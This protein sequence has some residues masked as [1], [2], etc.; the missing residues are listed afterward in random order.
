LR[1]FDQKIARKFSAQGS[2][3]DQHDLEASKTLILS[4]KERIQE[5][6]SDHA[7]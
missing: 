7:A 2:L 1:I 6:T 4:L 3:V 5:K